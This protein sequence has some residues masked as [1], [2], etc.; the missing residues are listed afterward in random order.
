MQATSN[1]CNACDLWKGTLPYWS[2]LQSA[3]AVDQPLDISKLIQGDFTYLDIEEI[4]SKY[5]RTVVDWSTLTIEL[6]TKH[7]CGDWHAEDITSELTMGV[8]VVNI[9]STFENLRTQKCKLSA[10]HLRV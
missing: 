8:S 3:S 5:W 6:T 9:C 2:D 7:F 10:V 4:L 1:R